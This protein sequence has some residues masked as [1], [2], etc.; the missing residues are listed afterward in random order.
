M[1]V[2]DLGHGP[3]RHGR[4]LP[5]FVLADVILVAVAGLSPVRRFFL[6]HGLIV[7]RLVGLTFVLFGA[8]SIAD[9]VQS[10]RARA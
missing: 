6:T 7:T 9:A 8:K 10:Y 1:P 3:P 5:R 4:R 2:A